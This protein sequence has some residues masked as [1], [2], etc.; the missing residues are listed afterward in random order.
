MGMEKRILKIKNL[1]ALMK[2][3]RKRMGCFNG[4]QTTQIMLKAMKVP[5]DNMFNGIG[6]L[7]NSDGKYKG[8]F[9]NGGKSGYG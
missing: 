9:E 5:L 7:I 3:G 1:Q 6:T 4:I 2:M 8:I